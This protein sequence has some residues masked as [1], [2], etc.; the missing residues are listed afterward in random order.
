VASE[1]GSDLGSVSETPG[2]E[3]ERCGEVGVGVRE[4]GA[5]EVDEDNSPISLVLVL[6]GEGLESLW[7]GF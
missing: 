3:L 4:D 6:V 5:G 7:D 1:R 2:C